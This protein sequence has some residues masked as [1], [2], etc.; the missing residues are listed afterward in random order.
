MI[1]IETKFSNKK[2]KNFSVIRLNIFRIRYE[3][4]DD[5]TFLRSNVSKLIKEFE[6]S[7]ETTIK[8]LEKNFH[9]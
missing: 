5:E 1:D 6:N 3:N 7:N 4:K 2:R 9:R 8:I